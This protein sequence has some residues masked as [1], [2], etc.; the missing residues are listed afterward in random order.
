VTVKRGKRTLL[1]RRAKLSKSC[2]YTVAIKRSRSH[3]KLRFGAR[4]GGN[5]VIDKR[6]ST[7][8]S[9]R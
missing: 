7:T 9:K 8:V 6:S 2:R 1:T 4:F 5:A 3:V